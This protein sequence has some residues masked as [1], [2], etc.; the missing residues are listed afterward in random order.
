ME[1][2]VEGEVLQLEGDVSGIDS[3]DLIPSPRY[4]G[5]CLKLVDRSKLGLEGD[6]G[7]YRK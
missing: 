5:M 3:G 6:V 7:V 1:N 2:C 4:S